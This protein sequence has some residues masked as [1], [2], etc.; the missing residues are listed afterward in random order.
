MWSGGS[1]KFEV[2]WQHGFKVSSYLI[3]FIGNN[4]EA[5][6]QLFF[7]T[8]LVRVSVQKMKDETSSSLFLT[9]T[10]G[11]HVDHGDP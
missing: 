4:A 10:S 8:V 2:W 11:G 6:S 7:S 9:Q 5:K 1:L 3:V